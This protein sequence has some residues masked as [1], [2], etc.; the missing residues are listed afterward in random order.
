M[1]VDDRWETVV[2]GLPFHCFSRAF[3][4]IPTLSA[5]RYLGVLDIADDS[6]RQSFRG[7]VNRLCNTGDQATLRHILLFAT[8]SG[9]FPR[10][11]ITLVL[12]SDETIPVVTSHTC[13]RTVSVPSSALDHLEA[14]LKDSMQE[15]CQN[16]GCTNDSDTPQWMILE[17]LIL[18]TLN[19]TLN[20]FRILAPGIHSCPSC[21]VAVIKTEGCNHV[22]CR[23]GTHWCF[24][25]GFKGRAREEVYRHMSKAGH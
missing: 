1:S 12:Q 14:A 22:E 21:G 9:V 24:E 18:D 8:G 25:C 13:S 15:C 17:Q 19:S 4:G 2:T 10:D 23:C 3:Q 5:E 7:V 16:A 6:L 20:E 11:K